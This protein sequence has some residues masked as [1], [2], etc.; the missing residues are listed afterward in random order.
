MPPLEC[1]GVLTGAAG[2][3]LLVLTQL[4]LDSFHVL[5]KDSLSSYGV[6]QACL[7]ASTGRNKTWVLAYNRQRQK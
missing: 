3:M 6:H 2:W 7:G 5:D 1:A 4:S